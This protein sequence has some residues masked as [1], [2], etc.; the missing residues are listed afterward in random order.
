MNTIF[1]IKG[2]SVLLGLAAFAVAGGG[3]PAFAETATTSSSEQP[4]TVVVPAP[5][6]ENQAPTVDTHLQS[7]ETAPALKQQEFPDSQIQATET[8]KTTP[9]PGTIPTSSAAL[10]PEQT[11]FQLSSEASPVAQADIDPGRPTRGGSSYVGIGANIGIGGGDSALGDGNLT[12]LSK[13]GVT[14]TFSVRPAIIL[15]DNT[16]IVVPV[17]YDFNLQQLNDPFADPLPIAPYVGAGAA[18]KTG[19]DSQLGFLLSAGVDVPLT[20]QFTATAAVNAGFF[21]DTD[22]GLLLGVGYNFRGF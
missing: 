18:I 17:T 16:T 13:V 5:V 12:I 4:A 10:T 15:G 11:K 22:V 8:T 20:R 1:S 6:A 7:S 14:R 2:V 3:V 9:V 19:D 21:D